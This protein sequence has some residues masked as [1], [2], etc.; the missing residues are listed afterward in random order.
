[1][2]L[3]F[4][5]DRCKRY[6]GIAPRE[7]RNNSGFRGALERFLSKVVTLAETSDKSNAERRTTC[8]N[9]LEGLNA[10][11]N[12]VISDGT[13]DCGNVRSEG[14]EQST[15][16]FGAAW[17]SSTSRGS[18][19]VPPP[20]ETPLPKPAGAT[21]KFSRTISRGENDTFIALFKNVKATPRKIKRVVNM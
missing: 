4:I 17:L 2:E 10:E 19:N 15:Q 14:S 11:V 6:P 7:F 8:L 5:L 9:L 12:Q 21:E 1:M 3:V 18:L 13:W 20:R 16:D